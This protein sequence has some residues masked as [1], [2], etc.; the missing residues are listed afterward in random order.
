MTQNA[1]AT[2]SVKTFAQAFGATA[3]VSVTLAGA[4]SAMPASDIY[5]KGATT[6]AVGATV[7]A[8]SVTTTPT[9]GRATANTRPTTPAVGTTAHRPVVVEA[10]VTGREFTEHSG[11]VGLSAGR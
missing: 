7:N 3:L 5:S 4:A 1:K 2:S 8:V 6:A 9:A 10:P 11:A